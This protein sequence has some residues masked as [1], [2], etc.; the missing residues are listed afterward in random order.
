MTVQNSEAVRNAYGDAWEAAIGTSAKVQFRTGAAPASCAAASIGTLLVEF[1]LGSDWSP[2]ASG[3]VKQLGSVPIAGTATGTGTAGHYRIFDS[4]GTTCHEQGTIT[5]TGGGGDVT[6]DNV[7]IA[8]GQGV[9][10]TGW[11]K[12]MP[13]A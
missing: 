5:A 2:A 9:N 7:N 11:T 1:S 3:G 6:I 8:I 12:T 13:G 10:I 4:A